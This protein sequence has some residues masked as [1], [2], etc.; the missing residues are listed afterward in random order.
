MGT[1][2]KFRATLV[3]VFKIGG[4]GSLLVFADRWSG[5]IRQGELI[6]VG[7]IEILVKGFNLHRPKDLVGPTRASMQVGEGH[8]EHLLASIGQEVEG[9]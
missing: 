4:R 2:P 9:V 7:G 3:D 1:Q 6:R 8:H 5:E